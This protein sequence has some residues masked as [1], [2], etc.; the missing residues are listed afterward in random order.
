MGGKPG[1]ITINGLDDINVDFELTV[2]DPIVTQSTA[3]A[4]ITTANGLTLHIPEPIQLNTDSDLTSNSTITSDSQIR[5]QTESGIALD[6]RPLTMDVCLKL[7]FGRLPPTCIRQ[8]YK[9]HF[10]ITLFGVEMLGF[11]FV[12]ESRVVVEDVRPAPQVAWGGE[13]AVHHPH[14][15]G[16]HSKNPAHTE[17]SGGLRIRLD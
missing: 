6:V 4:N 15:P 16:H 2:P 10:G 11:N 7:E 12:G 8:P 14:G 17:D 13:Q 1:E 3:T 5:A 9:H